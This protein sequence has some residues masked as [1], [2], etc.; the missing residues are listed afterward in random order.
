M[1]ISFGFSYNYPVSPL[2]QF[3]LSYLQ[4]N[5]YNINSK[6][7]LEFP[8]VHSLPLSTNEALKIILPPESYHLIPNHTINNENYNYKMIYIKDYK[9][10]ISECYVIII[11]R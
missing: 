8:N 9:I 10:H 4:R 7:F 1:N 5:K 3:I 2:P 6:L 11:T